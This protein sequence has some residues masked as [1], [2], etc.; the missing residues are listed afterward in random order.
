MNILRCIFFSTNIPNINIIAFITQINTTLYYVCLRMLLHYT[1]IYKNYGNNYFYN[2]Y[3]CLGFNTNGLML[4]I[5]ILYSIHDVFLVTYIFS[6]VMNN[7][8]HTFDLP[9]VLM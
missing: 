7:Y 8:S 5:K 6:T 1:I 4:Y 2:R 9:R 3:D